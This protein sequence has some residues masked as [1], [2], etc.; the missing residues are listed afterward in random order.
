MKASQKAAGVM[1]R[2]LQELK[3][4]ITSGEL[5]PGEQVRQEEMAEQLRVSRVPL[6]EA[7][8]VLADQG[9]LVHRPHQGYFVTKRAPGEQ[10]QIRRM[11]HLLENELMLTV[12]WPDQVC[13]DDLQGLNRS[14]RECILAPDVRRLIELNRKF[15]F[16]IFGL[17]PN[18]LILAEVQRLWSML[19][20]S[21]WNEFARAEDREKTLL[22]HEGLIAALAARDR[23]RCASEMEYH[24]YSP[25]IGHSIEMPRAAPELPRP[26]EQEPKP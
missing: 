24:R 13:I 22:E 8:N 10:A 4:L 16:R 3:G 20:S 14:M 18:H 7:M 9:L 11:L 17:S 6:R 5:S 15:H 26:N 2:T 23:V 25:G 1:E 19:E 21:M 12:H